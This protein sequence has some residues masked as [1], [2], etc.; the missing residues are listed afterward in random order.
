MNGVLTH[1]NIKT[2]FQCQGISQQ[3]IVEAELASVIQQRAA[4]QQD[5]D[6]ASER[7][8]RISALHA[9]RDQILGIN[10]FNQLFFRRFFSLSIS[11]IKIS[12]WKNLQ[13][14][15][16]KVNTYQIRNEGWKRNLTGSWNKS[17]TLILPTSG[18]NRRKKCPERQWLK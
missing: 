3:E 1:C 13:M 15:F 10:T 14:K 5:L 2:M 9:K 7:G 4:L 12:H 6:A 11:L 16:L 8:A 17:I 18:G